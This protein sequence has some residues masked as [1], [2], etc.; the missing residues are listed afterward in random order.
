MTAQADRNTFTADDVIPSTHWGKDHWTTLAY[1][2]AVMTDMA[3]FQVGFDPRMRSN[4]RHY[5]VMKQECPRPK[6]AGGAGRECMTPSPD[7]GT[8]L[9]DGTTVRN[10][11][12]WC[13]IQDMADA[14]L[15]TV[16]S[17]DVQPGA[18]LHFS[19]KGHEWAAALRRFKQGGGQC[20]EFNADNLPV[21]PECIHPEREYYSW[22]DMEFNVTAIRDA[23]RVGSVRAKKISFDKQAIAD[24]A[25]QVLRI[26]RNNRTTDQRG[27]FFASISSLAALKLPEE[28]LD[29]P[30]ILAFVGKGKGILNIDGSGPH[31][32]LIDG[33]HRMARSYFDDRDQYRVELLS[34]AQ[35]RPFKQ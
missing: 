20:A 25:T 34:Q 32:V 27:S 21:M 3:G 30:G 15:F 2:D 4:R 6:R 16:P 12:D 14:G 33:N 35:V 26:D 11:D 7:M 18:T 17:D 10:H 28:A 23:I 29:E 24:Y 1:V 31:Y 13:C 9:R 8:R 19:P 5:R 22:R